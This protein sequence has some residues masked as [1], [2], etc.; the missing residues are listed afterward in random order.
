MKKLIEKTKGMETPFE[1]LG[2][3]VLILS[4]IG[5]VVLLLSELPTMNKIYYISSLVIFNLLVV[6]YFRYMSYR[7]EWTRKIN[8]PQED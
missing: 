3:L 4:F 1:I 7:L 5:V 8:T 6:P 2:T